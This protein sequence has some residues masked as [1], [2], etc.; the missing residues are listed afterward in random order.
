MDRAQA[1]AKLT[2]EQ[3]IYALKSYSGWFP[4][5]VNKERMDLE[6]KRISETSL[7]FEDKKE[8]VEQIERFPLPC[9]KITRVGDKV[10]FFESNSTYESK[11]HDSLS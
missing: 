7:T 5:L 10:V 1:I 3:I 8:I 11:S 9:S 2:S 4:E 6:I